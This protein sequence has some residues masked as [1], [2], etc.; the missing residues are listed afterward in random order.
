MISE[1]Q[2]QHKKPNIWESKSVKAAKALAAELGRKPSIEE[3]AAKLNVADPA[4][5][6]NWLG[7]KAAVLTASVPA[8]LPE[9]PKTPET[10]PVGL[11]AVAATLPPSP[12]GLLIPQATPIPGDLP[13][14]PDLAA[15]AGP[16]IGRAQLIRPPGT[17]GL[18]MKPRWKPKNVEIGWALE[19][20]AP[21]VGAISPSM[22]YQQ[23]LSLGYTMVPF[24]YATYDPDKAERSGVMFA[25]WEFKKSIN[26]GIQYGP[27]V[28]MWKKREYY[29]KYMRDLWAMVRSQTDPAAIE[30][31]VGDKITNEQP[32]IPIDNYLKAAKEYQ[33]YS[34]GTF[35]G[36]SAD[37][38]ELSGG[39]DGGKI[40]P[41]Q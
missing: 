31:R 25:L 30:K 16:D 10:P 39:P 24:E 40:K 19:P 15:T 7:S 38:D 14:L 5:V 37:S 28:L 11:I 35:Q 29:D 34:A 12:T 21:T 2:V 4:K 32:H 27:Y 18:P 33:R 1:P 36:S 26:N 20:N 22:D 17:S 13:D 6:A 9:T 8:T 41:N 3:V 23:W